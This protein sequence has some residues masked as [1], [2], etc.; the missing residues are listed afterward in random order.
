MMF[1]IFSDE[2]EYRNLVV[3]LEDLKIR[4]YKIEGRV[5]L[6]NIVAGNWEEALYKV[7]RDKL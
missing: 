3:W 4:H 2:A 1:Q 6:R 7:C 5:A